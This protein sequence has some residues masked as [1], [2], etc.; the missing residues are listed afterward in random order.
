MAAHSSVSSSNYKQNIV[1]VQSL[2]YA[3]LFLTPWT[4]TSQASLS[5]IISL[6]FSNS[7]PLSHWCH[8]TISF[9]A[10]PYLLAL[11]LFQH[12]S[13]FQWVISLHQVAKVL[14]LQLQHQPFQWMLGLV[15]FRNDWFDLLAVQGTLKNLLKHHNLVLSLLYSP[16]L[17]SIHDYWKKT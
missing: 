14:E 13:V 9:S 12:Q 5:I 7:C 17:A 10:A 2:S 16:T 3:Q 4:A 6:S 1:V 11:N 8:P 15:S